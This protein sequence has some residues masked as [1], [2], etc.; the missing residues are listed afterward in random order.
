MLIRLSLLK[1]LDCALVMTLDVS[2]PVLPDTIRK[3]KI[4]SFFISDVSVLTSVVL[5]ERRAPA[6]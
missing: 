4:K 5:S 3:L 2:L 6:W 1:E